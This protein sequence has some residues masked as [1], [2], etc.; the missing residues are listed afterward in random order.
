MVNSKKIR[1]LVLGLAVVLS[2][3]LFQGCSAANSEPMEETQFLLGTVCSIKIYDHQSQEVLTK[4]FDRVREIEDKM[5]ANKEGTE[6]DA[7]DK[8]AGKGYVKV[9]DDTFYVIEKG[10]EYSEKSGGVFDIS[11]GPLV[12]LWGIGTDAARVPSMEE[13]DSR[14]SLVNYR[15]VL[16][17]KEEK[18][19]MLKQEG[20][21]LDL[22]GIAKGYAA[23]EV[24]RIL[25]ESGVEHAII[26]LGG[27]VIAINSNVGGKAWNIGIQNPFETRGEIVG[28]ISVTDK[29][30]VTSGIYERY[31]EVDGVKYHHILNPF[32]GYP[33]DSGLASVTV[34]TGSSIDADAMTKN[35]FYSGVEKG[36]EYL[37][38][39]NPEVEAIFITKDKKVYVTDGLKG[40][41]DITNPEYTLQ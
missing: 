22:G 30:V 21:A 10:L 41:I 27:N 8:E 3:A 16:L 14:K 38:E 19:V 26:N 24:S 23:D 33:M 29:T 32:T 2:A 20:M 13:I 40:S 37:E 28:S 5:S 18:S 11:I 4:A 25:R 9:S 1:S 15:D 7:I 12:K 35:L 39:N 36:L 17:N 6:V 34:V 31:L